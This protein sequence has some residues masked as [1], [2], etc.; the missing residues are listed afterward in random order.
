MTFDQLQEVLPMSEGLNLTTQRANLHQVAMRM[1]T[2]SR[3]N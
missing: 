2:A 3:W 1:E